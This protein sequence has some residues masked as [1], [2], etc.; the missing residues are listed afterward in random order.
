M[1]TSSHIK[2]D[3][4]VVLALALLLCAGCG[5]QRDDDTVGQLKA[6]ADVLARRPLARMD[7][8]WAPVPAPA[9]AAEGDAAFVPVPQVTDVVSDGPRYFLYQAPAAGAF[10]I[11]RTSGLTGADHWFGPFTLGGDG[12]LRGRR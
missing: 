7:D 10:W 5:V 6:V 1:N 11:R 4:P 12:E 9:Q 2:A 3:A 8:L